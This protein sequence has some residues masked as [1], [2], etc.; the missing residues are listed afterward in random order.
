ME[1]KQRGKLKVQQ[2][3]MI[4]KKKG[5]YCKTLVTKFLNYI[6][7]FP[8]MYPI[9]DEYRNVQ[10][11]ENWGSEFEGIRAY[12]YICTIGMQD[13]LISIS[14]GT[15]SE[16]NNPRFIYTPRKYLLRY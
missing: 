8:S 1:K 4:K 3:R 14:D 15:D 16:S 2:D 6:A 10:S 13:I 11:V 5:C 9:F 12:I 7:Y